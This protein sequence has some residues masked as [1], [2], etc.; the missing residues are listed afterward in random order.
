MIFFFKDKKTENN[1]KNILAVVYVSVACHGPFVSESI[2]SKPRIMAKTYRA[3]WGLRIQGH[4]VD[5]LNL[6]LFKDFECQVERE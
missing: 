6:I 4:I 3:D 1:G 2:P 5:P